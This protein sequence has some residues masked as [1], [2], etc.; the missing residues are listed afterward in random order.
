MN[1]RGLTLVEVLVALAIF[2]AV[3]AIGVAAMGLAARGSEQLDRAMERVSAVDRMRGLLRADLYQL[4]DRSVYEADTDRRRP[5]FIGGDALDEVIGDR[6]GEPLLGLVRGGWPNPGAEEPRPGL[7]AVTYLVRDGQLV[8]RTRPY[9]DAVIDTP[10]RDDV[11]LSGLKDVEIA[12]FEDGRWFP[13]TGRAFADDDEDGVPVALRL[14]FN[15]PDYGPMEH[16]FLI[17]GGV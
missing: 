8:R 16:L 5:A 15:H 2:S 13:E 12:F 7:Q 9:L 4:V 17:G 11:L 6:D 14:R 10:V 1:Q 3:S